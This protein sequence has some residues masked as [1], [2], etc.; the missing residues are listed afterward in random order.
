M[1]VSY[2]DLTGFQNNFS[3]SITSVE[4]I[5]LTPLFVDEARKDYRLQNASPCRGAGDPSPEYSNVDGSRNDM[6]AFGGPHPCDPNILVAT[7]VSFG[8]GDAAGFPGDSVVVGISISDAARL[9][10]GEFTVQYVPSFVSLGLVTATTLAQSLSFVVDTSTS[11]YMH[12]RFTSPTEI[13]SG[14][15]DLLL[16][17]FL[18][19]PGARAGDASSLPVS[20]V[21]LRD[22]ADQVLLIQEIRNGAIVLNPGSSPGRYVFVDKNG[23]GSQDGSR[24]HPWKKLQ[25]GITHAQPG[26]TVVVAPGEYMET[27][28]MLDSIHV[29]GSGPSVTTIKGVSQSPTLD[30]CSVMFIGVHG[31]RLSGCTVRTATAPFGGNIFSDAS[32]ADLSN[33]RI[34]VDGRNYAIPPVYLS[35]GSAVRFTNNYVFAEYADGYP[36]VGIDASR[37]DME[38][39][40]L[41][42]SKGDG[43]LVLYGPSSGQIG[44]N[45]ISFGT[46]G[47]YGLGASDCLRLLI[48]NNVFY[49][50]S[51]NAVGLSFRSCDSVI[52]MNNTINSKYIG[53]SE[54]TSS[55]RLMN[56]MITGNS[57]AGVKAGTGT[58]LSYNDIWGNTLNYDGTAPGTGDISSDPLFVNPAN[59]DYRLQSASPCRDAG[60]PSA[61]YADLDGSRNDIGVYGG[62]QLDTTMFPLTD[63][64]IRIAAAEVA[65]GDTFSLPVTVVHT[66]DLASS[67]MNIAYDPSRVRF[68]DARPAASDAGLSLTYSLTSDGNVSISVSGT[69]SIGRDSVV[70]EELVFTSTQK[71]GTTNLALQQVQCFTPTMSNI[72]VQ[73]IL[74]GNVTI[75]PAGVRNHAGLPLSFWLSQNYPNP[76]NPTTRIRYSLPQRAHVTLSVYNIV[77]QKVKDL[78]DAE[79]EAGEHD[80]LFDAHRV[81]SGVYFYRIQAGKYVQTRKLLVLR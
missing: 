13:G 10:R 46:A 51:G 75:G 55:A 58:I 38:R 8:T 23:T 70:L 81:A 26:D 78:V 36:L 54:V 69:Q 5:F 25:D 18:I 76:F 14:G 50:S 45:A 4:N 1:T 48:H 40:T 57:T 71:T 67:T 47:V 59:Q 41:G 22:S 53:V 20:L 66:R 65:V 29:M 3:G 42:S 28:Q 52:V 60:D 32:T 43:G 15:G 56:N 21:N 31:A 80:V 39:N 44:N 74:G 6:G 19:S 11:G 61:E 34:I 35:R 7:P 77:G 33:N 62:P 49:S 73:Q 12:I 24:Y 63:A 79:E 9:S 30:D 16:L 17:R 72:P 64:S 68:V 37:I 27:I 2:N